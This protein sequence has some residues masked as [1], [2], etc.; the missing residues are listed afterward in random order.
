MAHDPAAPI[1]TDAD[2][3]SADRPAVEGAS[4]GQVVRGL[5][6]LGP[7]VGA[8]AVMSLTLPGILG[9]VVLFGSAFG[10]ERLQEFFDG[11][12]APGPAIVAILFA[13]TTGSAIFP[14][15]AL[16]FACGA[17][18]AGFAVGGTVAMV[19]VVGGA[20]VGYFWGTVL[21]RKRVM[22]VID[23]HER[24]SLVRHALL[25]RSL[26]D[27][28]LAVG[29]IRFPPNSPFAL[30]N[31]VMSSSGVRVLPYLVG[32]AI[33]I[34]PRTLF[35]VWLGTQVG[36]LAEAQTAGGRWRIVVG[37]AIGLVT[38]IL[39]Y[40]LLSGWVRQELAR[41]TDRPLTP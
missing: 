26:S 37:V 12:G 4:T 22:A 16:S 11:L 18:F 8:L 35:A 21:A 9:T 7:V 24:A 1:P 36:D 40:K 3:A 19:G 38:F 14:T 31:L 33:G 27:E 5:R 20:M 25:D 15:Y 41:R 39:V 30:T 2:T 28:L 17:A 13:V 29:L 32:T 6:E 23:R 34:A 10:P